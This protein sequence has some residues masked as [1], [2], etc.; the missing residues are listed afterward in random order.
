MH[1]IFLN[2]LLHLVLYVINPLNDLYHVNIPKFLEYVQNLRDKF[3]FED[4]CIYM[5]NLSVHRSRA[6]KERLDEMSIAYIY[7]PAYSPD[8]NPIENVFS[9][10]KR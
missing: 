8:Y 3:F 9:I 6:V 2:Y 1:L 10:F 5:D 7:G 4:I